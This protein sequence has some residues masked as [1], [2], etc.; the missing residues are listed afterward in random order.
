MVVLMGLVDANV[1]PGTA[2]YPSQVAWL[3]RH[4][5]GVE[6]RSQEGITSLTVDGEAALQA[7]S[8]PPLSSFTSW[9]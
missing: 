9:L 1:Q 5:A 3:K 8:L 2:P 4:K 6:L 7:V